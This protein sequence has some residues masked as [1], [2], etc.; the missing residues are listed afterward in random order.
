MTA[1]LREQLESSLG[2]TYTLDREL[3]GGGMSRVFTAKE[4]ALGRPVVVKV[5]PPEL[6]AGVSTER[7]KREI[8][9]AARLQHPHIVPLLSAGHIDGLPWFTMPFVEGESLRVRLARNG[10][11][12][13]N[14]SVRILREI[15][16]ALAYAHGRGVVH[17]DIKPDNVLFSGDVA[18]VADFGVAKA[19]DAAAGD[20]T[21][22]EAAGVRPNPV[23]SLGV[24]LG[25]PAY[26]SPEQAT[27]DP[28]VDFRADIYAFGVVA[29]EMLTGLPPFTARNP[30]QLLAAQVTEMPEPI[31]RRRP[32]IPPALAAL[33]MRCLEKRPADRPQ[34]AAEIVHVLDD[35]TT[36]SGGT[37]PTTA[38]LRLPASMPA[39]TDPVLVAPPRRDVKSSLFVLGTVTL[40]LIVG[41]MAVWKRDAAGGSA[42]TDAHRGRIAVLPFENLGDS[43]DAY[44][45]DGITDAVR[46]KLTGLANME[47]IARASSMQ[48]R[49][50][51]KSP[52][53][54][55]RELGVR[56]LLTGT[57]RWAKGSGKSH[58][59]VSPELV[60]I[61]GDEA[62]SRWQQPFDAEIADVFRVQGEIAGKVAGAMQ[63]AVGG[64]DQARLAQAPTRN[65]AAY[66]AFLRG[67]ATYASAGSNPNV[68]RRAVVEYE[69]AV[70]LD[71]GFASAWAGLARSRSRLYANGTPATELARQA[72][73]A[74]DRALRL[75]PDAS[76]AHGARGLYFVWVE[77]N[78][79]AA[80]AEIERARAASPNDPDILTRLA[81]V[82]N[83]LGRFE[84]ALPNARAAQQL[85]PR[86]PGPLDPLLR[87]LTYLRRYPEAREVGDRALTLV[88]NETSI[89]TRIFV[90]LGEG[91][92]PGARRVIAD[93]GARVNQDQLVS[94]LATYQDLGWVLD[95]GAQ[96]RVLALGPEL[97]DN[98][99]GNW[100]FVRAQV[101]GWRGDLRQARAWGDTAAREF[102][103][104]IRATPND[105]QRHALR[106]LALAY[107]GHHAEAL[108]EGLR[109][110]A[111]LP[112]QNF[113]MHEYLQQL[114]VRIHL[115]SGD[116]EKAVDVLE[117]LLTRP[118]MLSSDWVRIDPTFESLKGHPRFE[119]L[120]AGR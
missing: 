41:G 120:V 40:V 91:D 42:A 3:S 39:A 96:R 92:L 72:R 103:A 97:F 81:M 1:D 17:R 46:G 7:F 65:P 27:A 71:S 23:T 16:S 74:A 33:V 109:G 88:P 28:T 53:E 36:P 90:S 116:P 61:Q 34:T 78:P 30:A 64:A 108:A 94:F 102:A 117:P 67:E 2:D 87:A 105:A 29:Y 104:Q 111:L 18:M 57:V 26:M 9:V 13:V 11:L 85:D 95:D 14:E 31:A 58:V 106:G 10:E 49:G 51:S 114:L 80:L 77:R 20:G 4:T 68:L 38:V 98:D 44:F 99:R 37:E 35:I 56:Y 76:F 86:S 32:A 43:S 19:I 115:L 101:F 45:A 119:K 47:V 89:L 100:A 15:A 75:A 54:I 5:L 70:A 69:Q 50:T 25:T 66:D 62:S 59:Q 84:D 118:G 83:Q 21:G 12:P 60:E 24:A 52:S 107:A 79:A 73:D 63:V 110:V 8:S 22:H 112:E 113:I 48:Y 82:Y 55:A 93:A 6:G